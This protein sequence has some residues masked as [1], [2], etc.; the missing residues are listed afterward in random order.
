[1][2]NIP[3]LQKGIA[4]QENALSV[5]LEGTRVPFQREEPSTNSRRRSAGRSAF[6]TPFE[7]GRPPPGRA[8]P[9]RRQCQHRVAKALYYPTLSLTGF[10]GFA[11]MDLSDLFQD[12]PKCGATLRR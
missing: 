2:A 3:L 7:T 5:L 8:E 1:M 4:Q 6:G 10:F 11:S 12:L 9:C